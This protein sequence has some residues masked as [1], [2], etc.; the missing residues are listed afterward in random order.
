MLTFWKAP[1]IWT[2]ILP[3]NRMVN[4]TTAIELDGPLTSYDS[5]HIL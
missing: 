1:S 2:E 4:V 5:R 3:E